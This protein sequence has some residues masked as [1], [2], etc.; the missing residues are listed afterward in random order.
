MSRS[1]CKDSFFESARDSRVDGCNR[2]SLADFL[3]PDAGMDVEKRCMDCSEYG[4]FMEYIQVKGLPDQILVPKTTC[5]IGKLFC[6]YVFDSSGNLWVF[7]IFW[8]DREH[9]WYP[10]PCNGFEFKLKSAIRIYS[11]GRP[12]RHPVKQA[13]GR[14]KVYLNGRSPP[15]RRA[16]IRGCPWVY[17][18]DTP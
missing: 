17:K 10:Y 4:A 18:K 7:W 5:G 1:S 6:I 14:R 15:A 2:D 13:S 16:W 11:L 3:C 9:L 12:K 8:A